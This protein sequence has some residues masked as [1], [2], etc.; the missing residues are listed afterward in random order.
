MAERGPNVRRPIRQPQV[1][2]SPGEAERAVEPGEVCV[3]VMEAPLIEEGLYSDF[4]V[5]KRA[6]CRENGKYERLKGYDEV[7]F[8]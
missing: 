4:A 6:V 1:M 3:E 5:P 8:E 7:F 2:I